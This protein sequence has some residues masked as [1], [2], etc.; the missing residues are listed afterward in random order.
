MVLYPKKVTAVTSNNI[1]RGKEVVH[2]IAEE[3]SLEKKR[4]QGRS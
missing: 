4:F 1:S 2:V 3:T